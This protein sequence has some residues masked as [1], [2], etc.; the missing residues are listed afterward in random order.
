MLK[1]QIYRLSVVSIFACIVVVW[2]SNSALAAKEPW[3]WLF[4]LRADE[5][6]STMINPLAV[7]ADDLRDRY[8]VADT[9]NNRLVSFDKSGK[10]INSF[11]AA[12]QL[13]I[14]FDMVRDNHGIIW[15]VEKERNSL[16]KI[17]IKNKDISPNELLIDGKKVYPDKVSILDGQF[18]VL[19]KSTGTI[20]VFDKSLSYQKQYECT[21]CDT[22]FTDFVIKNNVIYALEQKSQ[23]VYKYKIDGQLLNTIA[24][25]D[26]H[27]F[28]FAIEI[29]NVGNIYILDKHD[30]SISVYDQR[31][32]LSY[33]FLSNGHVRG[34]LYHPEDLLF[35]PWGRL[36]VVDTGN[37]RV[38][39]FS[40]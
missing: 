20:N 23:T 38:E 1:H 14:P 34:K 16:T 26:D 13:K 39:V 35:D 24:L 17:D 12:D 22:G 18:Y 9:G 8:Y 7:Y 10:Y 36:C 25:T 4:S 21:E 5:S 11:S 31:G 33:K 3:K 28:P 19:D 15:L 6:G 37:G 40:R 2:G 27:Q 29:D 30:G 32:K